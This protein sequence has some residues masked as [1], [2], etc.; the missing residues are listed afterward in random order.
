VKRAVR[1]AAL[2]GWAFWA[3]VAGIVLTHHV[4]AAERGAQQWK[5]EVA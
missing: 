2:A 4:W 5:E 1:I 3:A